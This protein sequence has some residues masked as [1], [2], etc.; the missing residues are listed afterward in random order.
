MGASG[1]RLR[2]DRRRLLEGTAVAL[3]FLCTPFASA[4]HAAVD[5]ALIS[6][7]KLA[8]KWIALALKQSGYNADFSVESLAEIERFFNE[9]SRDGRPLPGGRLADRTGQRLF[10]LGSYV[11]EVI[12]REGG[13][14]WY[15]ES[16]DPDAEINIELQLPGGSRIWPMHRVIQRLKNGPEENIYDYGRIILQSLD[17]VDEPAR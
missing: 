10:A 16:G 6:D 5:E 8:A 13:G 9:H 7:V 14:Q 15:A 1:G 2:I 12:R 4:V 11:G 3:P 17:P